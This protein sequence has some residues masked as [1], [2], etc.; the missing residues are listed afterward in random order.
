MMQ[1]L[2][3]PP[4]I[5][6]WIDGSVI[7]RLGPDIAS[8]FPAMPHGMLTM[9]FAHCL[10]HSVSGKLHCPPITCHTLNTQ[11][12]VYQHAVEITALGL[13][14]RPAAAACLLGNAVGAVTNQVLEWGILAGEHEAARIEN[15]V[16]SSGSDVERLRVL[17]ASFWRTMSA[18]SL[19]RD[20]N[21]ARLC[22]VIGEHGAMAGEY[23]GLGRRQLERQTKAILGLSPKRFQRLVRFQ[24]ALSIAMNG[25][26]S[27]IADLAQQAGFYDQSHFARDTRELAGVTMSSLLSE[28]HP[29]SDWWPLATRRSLAAPRIEFPSVRDALQSPGL[30]RDVDVKGVESCAWS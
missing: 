15:E 14:V 5:A 3:P 2:P 23:L 18:V 12:V 16:G 1:V 24:N 30:L 17:M 25:D 21:Y 6:H 28:A 13:L 10:D 22:S 27:H 9:R 8:H 11:P 29:Y 26:A 7:I 20:V 4:A 19:G